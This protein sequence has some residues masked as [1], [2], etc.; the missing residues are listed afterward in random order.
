MTRQAAL[1]TGLAAVLVLVLFWFFLFQPRNDEI[2]ELREQTDAAI[3]QQAQLEQEIA[4]LEA[5]RAEAPEIE[6]A[7]ATAEGIVPRE[8]A[9]PS[10][11]R[12]LQLA[13][14]DAGVSLDTIAPGRPAAVAGEVPDLAEIT[15]AVTLSGSYF[16]IVD[17]LRRVEDPTI[18]PRGIEWSSSL[19]SVQDHP[20]LSVVLTGEMYAVLPA[21][22]PATT[23]EAVAPEE[24]PAAVET[25]P[26][27]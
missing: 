3:A 8:L 24:T 18:L 7:L 17:F 25:E 21:P 23:E 13:A 11:L 1:L 26:A 6:A 16:Q 27:A 5:V 15:I 2:A 19:L 12:Q 10:A 14:D 22:A 20:T 4:R 9:L